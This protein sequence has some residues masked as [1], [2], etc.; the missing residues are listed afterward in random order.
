MLLFQATAPPKYLRSKQVQKW[1][2]PPANEVDV[3]SESGEPLA[4][5]RKLCLS[6]SHK[7]KDMQANLYFLTARLYGTAYGIYGTG[8]TCPATKIVYCTF[9]TYSS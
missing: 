9:L 3:V 6:F 1:S 2:T 7:A 5:H 8:G 4:K